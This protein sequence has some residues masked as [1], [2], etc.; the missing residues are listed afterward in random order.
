MRR[1]EEKQ[2]ILTILLHFSPSSII[3]HN[4][5]KENE[6]KYI[7]FFSLRFPPLPSPLFLSLPPVYLN[8]NNV[9]V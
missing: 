2:K 7:L 3:N 1:K 9:L 5:S 8:P 6:Y 4:I